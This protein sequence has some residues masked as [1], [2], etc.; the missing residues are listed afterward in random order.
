MRRGEEERSPQSSKTSSFVYGVVIGTLNLPGQ[1]HLSF[2]LSLSVIVAALTR[3][4]RR[5]YHLPPPWLP[6]SLFLF[7]S[8]MISCFLRSSLP[9]PPTGGRARQR[10]GRGHQ[11]EDSR[12]E[13]E[14]ADRKDGRAPSSSAP[15]LCTLFLT[16]AAQTMKREHSSCFHICGCKVILIIIYL[17]LPLLMREFKKLKYIIKSCKTLYIKCNCSNCCLR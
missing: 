9:R 7:H 4:G 12:S 11:R 17:H 5:R 14:D 15:H 6:L 13:Q 16:L 2:P 8:L 1:A 3:H 10:Q